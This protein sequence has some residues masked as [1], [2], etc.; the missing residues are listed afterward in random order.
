MASDGRRPPQLLLLGGERL[1]KRR[2]RRRP[3]TLSFC[4]ARTTR[5]RTTRETTRAVARA[6]FA[7]SHR[8]SPRG[9]M[10]WDGGRRKRRGG[11]R[12][13]PQPLPP[14]PPPSLTVWLSVVSALNCAFEKPRGFE[15]SGR[16]QKGRSEGRREGSERA[17]PPPR[18]TYACVMYS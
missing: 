9:R 4:R 5:A 1:P 3:L 17:N 2:R 12:Q 14:P 15:R 11:R 10:E 7:R 6:D 16:R 18:H 13:R 8:T